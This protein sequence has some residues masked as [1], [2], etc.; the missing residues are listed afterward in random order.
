MLPMIRYLVPLALMA[1]VGCN[2]EMPDRVGHDETAGH[3]GWRVHGNVA[4][5]DNLVLEGGL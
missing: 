1:L 4:E 2:K 5:I 3:D